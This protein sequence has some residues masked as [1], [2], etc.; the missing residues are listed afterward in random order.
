MHKYIVGPV[1]EDVVNTESIIES[2]NAVFTVGIDSIICL[3]AEYSM[4]LERSYV[5]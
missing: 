5:V 1:V 3:I 4:H 2:I